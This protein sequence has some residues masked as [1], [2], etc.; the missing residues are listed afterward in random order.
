MSSAMAVPHTASHTPRQ[1]ASHT[2]RQIAHLCVRPSFSASS[3]E[4]QSLCQYRTSLSAGVSRN[5]VS[6][7]DMAYPA[8]RTIG[9]PSP[10]C[11]FG[12]PVAVE[13]FPASPMSV[14]D[15]A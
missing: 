3:W 1:I 8:R 14:P 10:Q 12:P 5:T 13:L 4:R 6:V 9:Y 11:R 7:T 2:R 15:I